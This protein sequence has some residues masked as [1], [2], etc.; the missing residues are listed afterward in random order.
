MPSS[1]VL[2]EIQKSVAW[3]VM[4]TLPKLTEVTEDF[5]YDFLVWLSNWNVTFTDY[6]DDGETFSYHQLADDQLKDLC[7]QWIKDHA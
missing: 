2:Q 4:G 7:K 3:R 1:H 5:L 6:T